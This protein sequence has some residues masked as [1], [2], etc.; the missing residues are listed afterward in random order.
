LAALSLSLSRNTGQAQCG[1]LTIASSGLAARRA[2]GRSM[3]P[4][5]LV[6]YLVKILRDHGG[7]GFGW[8]GNRITVRF[9]WP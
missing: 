8:T 4:E 5:D 2:G 9:C 3:I 6:L 1:T 7:T